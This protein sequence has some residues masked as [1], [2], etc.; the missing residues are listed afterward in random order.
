MNKDEYRVVYARRATRE[1]EGLPRDTAH[2]IAAAIA[3]LKAQPRPIR[4]IK[5]KGQSVGNY[6][7]RVGNY[8]VVYDINDVSQEV[9][10]VRIQ[11]RR[12]VYR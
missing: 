9:L 1:L 5:L 4:A 12:D 10:I 7:I 3:A 2:R 6:R 11:H 8:R